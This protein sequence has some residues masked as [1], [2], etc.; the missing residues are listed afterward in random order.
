[1]GQGYFHQIVYGMIDPPRHPYYEVDGTD[2]GDVFVSI[3]PQAFRLVG[4]YDANTDYLGVV[5][6]TDLPH[7]HGE[8]DLF[9]DYEVSTF[10]EFVDRFSEKRPY[11]QERIAAWDALRAHAKGTYGVDLPPGQLLVV[12][13]YD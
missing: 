3:H 1:M 10:Q 7:S 5:V 8:E 13:D 12:S 9:R 6:A 2:W 11:V 4:V